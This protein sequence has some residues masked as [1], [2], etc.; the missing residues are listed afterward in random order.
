VQEE[1]DSKRFDGMFVELMQA[2]P[3][4]TR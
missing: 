3:A 1:L 2:G 4:T